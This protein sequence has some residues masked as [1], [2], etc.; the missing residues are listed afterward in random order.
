VF[1]AGASGLASGASNLGG[2]ARGPLPRRISPFN[3]SPSEI[4][5]LLVSL[6]SPKVTG[7]G[8]LIESKD[9]REVRRSNGFLESTS[10]AG[11]DQ[12]RQP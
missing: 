3:Y 2:L 6:G 1:P 12:L 10:P 7:L 4:E 5:G 11:Q 8:E 9:Y